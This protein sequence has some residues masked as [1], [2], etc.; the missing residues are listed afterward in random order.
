[1]PD[2]I[3]V[4]NDFGNEV[5]AGRYDAFNGLILLGDGK[6]NFSASTAA[7]SGF[8][9]PGDAK[10]LA[11]LHCK[12]GDLFV[13]SQNK[14]SLEVFATSNAMANRTFIPGAL[15]VSAELVRDDGKKQLIEF[16]FGSGYLSQSSRTVSIPPG[17]REITIYDSRGQSRKL[18]PA[19]NF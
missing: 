1:M 18:A 11:R 14:D 13:A 19:S 16:Y 12:T 15:D 10:A 5:F 8:Y 4:G 3:M 9:V 6:G 17:V 2:V 7:E